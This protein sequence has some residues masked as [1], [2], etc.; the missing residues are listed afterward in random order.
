LN[1]LPVQG[2][3]EDLRFQLSQPFLK[4]TDDRQV[5]IDDEIDQGMERVGRTLS[6][7]GRIAFGARADLGV[8]GRGAMPDGHQITLAEKDVGFPEVH[9]VLPDLGRVQ[10]DEECVAIGLDLGSL[11]RTVGVLDG[12]V[13]QP[14]LAL[15]FPE[16]LFA[17]F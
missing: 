9:G 12:E 3:A 14:E 8:G 4:S 6:E 16:Q 15:D 7:Q 5:T 1:R 10:H 11:M 13:M 2:P 17:R